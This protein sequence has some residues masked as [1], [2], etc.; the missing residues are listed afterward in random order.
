MR[1]LAIFGISTIFVSMS[2][3]FGSSWIPGDLDFDGDVDFTDFNLFAQNFGRSGGAIGQP[4]LAGA[5]AD[6]TYVTV[7]VHEVKQPVEGEIPNL[8]FI[9]IS[10]SWKN[11]DADAED[12]GIEVGLFAQD[13]SGGL[14]YPSDIPDNIPLTMDVALYK[15]NNDDDVPDKPAI[16][17]GQF[18]GTSKDF[19]RASIS[20]AR[21]PKEQIKVDPLA[22]EKL[23]ILKVSLATPKQGAFS[24][25]E[26]WVYLYQ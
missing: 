12:D 17:T 9:E 21:I 18:K 10:D 22:D 8:A 19:F 20:L 5:S 6:T 13:I 11:W 3:V 1:R 23:G 24:A 16:Y 2:T 15:D 7:V 26:T 4:T 14:I 25:I